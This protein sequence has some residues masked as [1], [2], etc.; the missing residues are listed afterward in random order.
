MNRK[1]SMR[2]Y[3][4][5]ALRLASPLSISNGENENTDSDVLRDGNGNLFIPGTSLAGAFRDYQLRNYPGGKESIKKIYGYAEGEKGTMSPISVQDLYFDGIPKVSVRDGVQLTK[6]K[7]V[8]N[9]FDM[10][11]IETGATG[12]LFLSYVQRT[13]D[14]E[15]FESVI[16]HALWALQNG[17]IRLGA[18]KN[19]GFGR[20]E[21]LEIYEADFTCL[22]DAGQKV[23]SAGNLQDWLA[24]IPNRKERSAYLKTS[25]YEDW[26]RK[27]EV[28]KSDYLRIQIPLK[29]EGGISIRKYSTQPGKADFEHITCN[30]EPVIPGT[31]WNGAIRSAANAILDELGCKKS[32]KHIQEWFGQIKVK[33]E[34]SESHQSLVVIGESILKN[35]TQ[36]AATRSAIDRFSGAARSGALYTALS[37][38]GGST[39]LE[40][41]VKKDES[42]DWKAF[43]G[44]L[45]LVINE[46]R[47]GY[48]AI[49]GQTSIGR[50][51]FAANGKAVFSESINS[52]ECLNELYEV[53]ASEKASAD[54]GKKAGVQS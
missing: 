25:S 36:L 10:E 23:G 54:D 7:G 11:I 38:F 28:G 42:R 13:E 47:S 30:G 53:L 12:T 17:T 41:L 49:G 50:G 8:D 15:D 21:L 37:Y 2:K 20:V 35:A 33:D 18:N 31:S 46:L 27:H 43:V 3:Y 26:Q 6:E 14:Q 29:L 24:F 52:K 32:T 16:T 48:L 4:A 44:L 5:V 9:K 51:I 22:P 39:T 1:I 34:D 40:I 45:M 19:R